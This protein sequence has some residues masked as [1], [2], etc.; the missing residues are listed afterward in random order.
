MIWRRAVIVAPIL[1]YRF[2]AATQTS[3]E[4]SPKGGGWMAVKEIDGKDFVRMI[5]DSRRPFLVDFWAPWCMPC[6]M[7]GPVLDQFSD[8]HGS[9]VDVF[10]LNVEQNQELADELGIKGIPTLLAIHDRKV[11]KNIVGYHPLPEL[12][13]ELDRLLH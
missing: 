3:S 4:T 6:K 7:T 1:Q 13:K 11:I 12:E 5:I 9:K 2:A 8:K 10:K